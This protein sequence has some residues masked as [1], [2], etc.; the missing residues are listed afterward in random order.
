MIK[1]LIFLDIDGVLNSVQSAEMYLAWDNEYN[2][3]RQFCLNSI[4]MLAKIL[5]YHE[6]C[7]III[8]STWR[9]GCKTIE[10]LKDIFE[11][12][13]NESIRKLIQNRII[14]RTPILYKDIKI[15]NQIDHRSCFRGEEIQKWIDDN[16]DKL[17]VDFKFVILD[18]DSD[19]GYL[20]RKVQSS[21]NETAYSNLPAVADK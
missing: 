13:D 2:P 19:M 14:G 1:K 5:K 12:I 20:Y 7:K 21:A 6:D 9:L 17:D 18:D 8:S 4:T 16:Q 15:G 11:P 3:Y 10:D